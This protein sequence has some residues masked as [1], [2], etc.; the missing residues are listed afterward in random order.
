MYPVE[1][2]QTAG[3]TGSKKGKARQNRGSWAH[4]RSPMNWEPSGCSNQ[5]ADQDCFIR[6]LQCVTP[7]T[8]DTT[9]LLGVMIYTWS[10]KG[11]P[12]F[13]PWGGGSLCFTEQILAKWNGGNGTEQMWHL[14]VMQVQ[15]RRRQ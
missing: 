15:L 1:S 3:K 14:P 11:A 9:H 12:S 6:K 10:A 4:G 2:P 8:H 13:L 7:P 5:R